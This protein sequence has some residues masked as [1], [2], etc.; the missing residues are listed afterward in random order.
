MGTLD[1]PAE[2][3]VVPPTANDRSD[4]IVAKLTA[5]VC[6]VGCAA[7][8]LLLGIIRW[9]NVPTPPAS[10]LNVI[11]SVLFY[12]AGALTVIMCGIFLVVASRPM[13]EA[14]LANSEVMGTEVRVLR[15]GSLVICV[16]T[17]SLFV[18]AVFSLS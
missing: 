5:V 16:I 4:L 15:F 13:S 6:A 7:L 14:V 1:E 9:V 10:G 2:P 11:A 8:V 17:L 18:L 12:G 3:E